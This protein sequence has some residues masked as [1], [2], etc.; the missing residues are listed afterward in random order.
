LAEPPAPHL[1]LETVTFGVDESPAEHLVCDRIPVS[2]PLG[3]GDAGGGEFCDHT[4]LGLL[5][6]KRLLHAGK[7]LAARRASAAGAVSRRPIETNPLIT[8]RT[9]SIQRNELAPKLSLSAPAIGGPNTPPRISQKPIA[10][11]STVACC[12]GGKVSDGIVA[13]KIG[14][15]PLTIQPMKKIGTSTTA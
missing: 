6:G 11:P 9:M 2:Q 8:A 10:R 3:R 4:H 13:M 12:V 1:A 15:T 5:L 7:G 14:N